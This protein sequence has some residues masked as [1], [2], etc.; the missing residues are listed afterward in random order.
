M[1]AVDYALAVERALCD[2]ERARLLRRFLAYNPRWR[3]TEVADVLATLNDGDAF[4][5]LL[6]PLY[7]DH[8]HEVPERGLL[9]SAALAAAL[10]DGPEA[11]TWA[12]VRDLVLRVRMAC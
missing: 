12:R 11:V 7:E 8:G 3:G 10:L 1:P 4:L 9:A 6:E 2:E 5:D